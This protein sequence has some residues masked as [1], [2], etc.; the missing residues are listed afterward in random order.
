MKIQRALVSV[1]DKTGIVEFA[2]ELSAMGIEIVSSG[3]TARELAKSGVKVV[4]VSD[5]TGFPEMMDGRVKTLHPK[6]HGAILADRSKKSH[7]EEAKKAGVELIDLVVVNLYPFERVTAKE[8]KDAVSLEEA[9]ENIDIGGPTLVRS[10]AKNYA[11]VGVVV[12]P[13]HYESVITELKKEKGGLSEE[14]RKQLALEAFEHVAHY[15][16]VIEQYLRRVFG[17]DGSTSKYPDYLNLSFKKIQNMRYGENS[18]QTAAFY[19]DNHKRDPCVSSGKCLQGKELSFNNIL[20]INSAFELVKEFSEP[21]TVIVKH[22]NPCGVATDSK[23]ADSYKKALAVDSDAAFGGVIA[24]NQ[25]VDDAALA[26]LICERFYEVIVA[27]HFSDSARAVFSTKKN[28][29]LIEMGALKLPIK[30]SSFPDYRSVVG[31]FLVQDADTE[32]LNE[33]NLKIVTKRKPTE[34]EMK[35]LL[36]AWTVCKYVRSNAIIYAR[37]NRAVG[38]GAGQMKRVDAARL[39]AMIAESHGDTV[40]GCA[41]ASDA[42]FPFRDGIDEAAKRGVTCVIQPGGSIKDQEVIAAADAHGMAMVFTGIR[43]FRH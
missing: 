21:T 9:I 36:Y 34:Q 5:V 3:G 15:D 16:V 39:A 11:S 12:N 17:N 32:L 33:G 10:A 14:T 37:V 40:K 1:F 28:L 25:D 22:N 18:H 30:R 19:L 31:G 20:D 35:G 8:G 7:L 26:K 24:F 23:L 41:M 43:H 2:K 42:F 29:R 13:K 6:I 27:P 4:E 38:I